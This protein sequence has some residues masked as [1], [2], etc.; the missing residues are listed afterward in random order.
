M[1]AYYFEPFHVYTTTRN[2]TW[3]TN[4]YTYKSICPFTLS[5]P[6]TLRLI[7]INNCPTYCIL[8]HL[9]KLF[10]V[11]LYLVFFLS[12]LLQLLGTFHNPPILSSV[13]YVFQP[14]IFF[15]FHCGS[16]LNIRGREIYSR[17]DHNFF[18]FPLPS[19]CC[20]FPNFRISLVLLI[21]ALFLPSLDI[22]AILLLECT[23]TD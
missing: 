5:L 22:L 11:C 21:F 7:L 20:N 19:I 8:S 15:S 12:F 23:C 14:D 3:S 4:T 13:H 17:I 1:K 18:L 10:L 6:F 2:W 16:L 9:L